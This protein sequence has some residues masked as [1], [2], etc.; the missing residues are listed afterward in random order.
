MDKLNVSYVYYAEALKAH[1]EHLEGTIERL[2]AE[3]ANLEEGWK[4]EEINA[5]HWHEKYCLQ[6]A[7]NAKLR[8]AM[9]IAFD[10]VKIGDCNNALSTMNEA[11]AEQEE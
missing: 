11:L 8:E 3:K 5:A 6:L 2:Q 10:Q 4:N 7:K 9:L 1:I